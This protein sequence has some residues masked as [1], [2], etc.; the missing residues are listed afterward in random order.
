MRF[1]SLSLLFLI[2]PICFGQ[3]RNGVNPLS[4][5]ALPFDPEDIKRIENISTGEAN[6][7]IVTVTASGS[8]NY[9]YYIS[10]D[11]SK[12]HMKNQISVEVIFDTATEVCIIMLSIVPV[13]I[14]LDLF[15]WSWFLKTCD[16]V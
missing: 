7:Y 8:K 14:L 10:H 3:Q 13:C 15:I 9:Q 11:C 4:N 12:L 2:C 16:Q 5:P 1:F 6:Y